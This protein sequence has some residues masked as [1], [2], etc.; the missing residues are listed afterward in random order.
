MSLN[1]ILIE[2]KLKDFLKEDCSFIDVSSQIIPEKPRVSAKIIAKSIGFI[3]G[4]E[5]IEILFN[6]KNLTQILRSYFIWTASSD[7]LPRF[8]IRS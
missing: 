4:F 1:R 8:V 6:P 2:E 3:S 5:E 7:P